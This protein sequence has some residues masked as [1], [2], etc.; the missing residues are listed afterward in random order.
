[1]P[2]LFAASLFAALAF[3]LAVPT[4]AADAKDD[5]DDAD[6]EVPYE[7]LD[8]TGKNIVKLTT[9]AK[10]KEIGWGKDV[11]G[12]RVEGYSLESLLAAAR[13]LRELPKLNETDPKDV[14][15]TPAADAP[16]G[17]APKAKAFDPV[18]ESRATL[19]RAREIVATFEDPKQKDAYSTLIAAVEKIDNT[20]AVLGGPKIVTRVIRP[21][22]KHN[23]KF[24]VI[25]GLPSAVAVQTVGAPIRFQMFN[26][27]GVVLFN[28]VVQVGNFTWVPTGKPNEKREFRLE[29]TN[30]KKVPVTYTAAVQ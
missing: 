13:M 19:D 14:E 9:A 30:S 17:E 4:R 10:L 2:R 22:E 1:L 21:G 26:P 27:R 8:E 18:A 20:R 3:P 25:S 12:G 15:V 6:P 28:Q 23:L 7:K 24:T 29:V 16:K 5:A 11:K